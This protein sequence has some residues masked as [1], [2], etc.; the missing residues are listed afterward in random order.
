ML[1]FIDANGRRYIDELLA[2]LQY[3]KHRVAGPFGV[4]EGIKR[5]AGNFDRACFRMERSPRCEE[6][7]TSVEAGAGRTCECN[8]ERNVSAARAPYVHVFD[9]LTELQRHLREPH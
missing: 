3:T 7:T 6:T 1:D 9:G 5:C 2:L 4:R 8:D